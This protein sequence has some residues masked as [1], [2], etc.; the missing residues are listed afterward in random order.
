MTPIVPAIIPTSVKQ[1]QAVLPNFNF[2]AEIHID[3][4]DGKFVPFIS[5]P[6]EPKGQPIEVKDLTDS[7]TLE[8][9]LMVDDPVPTAKE[10]LKAGADML[11]FHVET[12]SLTDFIDFTNQTKVSVGVSALND[13]P[14][15][16][17]FAYAEQADYIQVMGIA[18]IGTQGQGFDERALSRIKSLK[19][20]FPHLPLT[21][22][23]SVN[24]ETIKTL[25]IA[26]ADRFICGSAL[27]KASDPKKAHFE[28]IRLL[29][30]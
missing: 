29:E 19:A 13:T 5:W 20:K 6:Y 24:K 12:I 9:D 1:L 8:V 18:E 7:F 21:V 4:V 23:G 28:L 2:S 3:V 26:G 11:V 15:E 16:T 10:W 17:L 25:A 14:L 27:V 30:N 22:D